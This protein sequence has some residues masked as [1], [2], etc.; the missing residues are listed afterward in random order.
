MSAIRKPNSTTSPDRPILVDVTMLAQL[1]GRSPQSLS[2][3]DKRGK[4]PR[5]LKLGSSKRWDLAEIEQWVSAKC[6]PREV[7]E[8]RSD[9]SAASTDQPPDHAKGGA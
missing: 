1:L 4:L 6:P 7:W 2:R 5:A 9:K 8:S 3:D